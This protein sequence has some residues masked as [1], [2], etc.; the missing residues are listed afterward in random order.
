MRPDRNARPEYV[1]AFRELATRICSALEG[2]PKRVLPVK[3][4]VAG[5]AAIHLYTGARVSKDVDAVF[6]HR[7]ALPA[8]L[9]ISYRDAD[10][11]ARLL[12]FDHQYN[13]TLALMHEDA[14]ED[15]HALSLDG[16]DPAV[17]D[18]RLLSPVDLAVT[19]IGRFLD[20]DRQDIIALA[21]RRLIRPEPLRQRAE[22]A[23]GGYVGN[24]D[25]VRGSIQMA[26]RIVADEQA[27]AG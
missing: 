4:Y 18:V 26:C 16:I 12:Y 22:E 8:N 2:S 24:T 11:A 9:E 27:R 23:L 10:G 7:I 5:G 25:W 14:H 1:T 13:D 21:R 6:S 19:K 20:H 3:M 15:S 17:L